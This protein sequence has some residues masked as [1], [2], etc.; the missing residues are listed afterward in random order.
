M[1][2]C[3]FIAF[4][5]ENRMPVPKHRQECQ[6]PQFV[7]LAEGSIGIDLCQCSWK[8]YSFQRRTVLECDGANVLDCIREYHTR[9][10]CANEKHLKC[11]AR[12]LTDFQIRS[13]HSIPLIPFAPTVHSRQ[14][15]EGAIPCRVSGEA[16]GCPVRSTEEKAPIGK[17]HSPLRSGSYWSK[18]PTFHQSQNSAANAKS[19]VVWRILYHN[20]RRLWARI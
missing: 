15:K 17:A 4:V 18:L 19:C 12:Q 11:Q 9:Y 7:A 16:V 3:A 20:S 6:V 5:L 1:P 14:K 2:S 13:N 10:V 8:F